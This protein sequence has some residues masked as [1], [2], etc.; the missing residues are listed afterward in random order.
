M[1]RSRRLVTPRRQRSHHEGQ[2]LQSNQ[3]LAWT[4]YL[5]TAPVC[6]VCRGCSRGG[7]RARPARGRR[8]RGRESSRGCRVWPTRPP[9][10][11]SCW[12]G[13]IRAARSTAG[14]RGCDGRDQK[15]VC[16]TSTCAVPTAPW[17][18]LDRVE[19]R[20]PNGR[21]RA[22]RPQFEEDRLGAE[23]DASETIFGT[24]RTSKKMHVH[25][26]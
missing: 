1:G 24:R 26:G 11:R 13:G 6:G 7:Q 16:N 14:A 21:A 19:K 2:F 25:S 3:V 17:R 4:R 10:W 20:N 9:G 15:R 8:A 5:V 23:E 18:L 12:L 22:L